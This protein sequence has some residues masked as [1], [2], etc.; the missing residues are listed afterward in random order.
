MRSFIFAY[1][2][3]IGL[4]EKVVIEG[5]VMDYPELS[6]GETKAT[7]FISEDLTTSTQRDYVLQ[8]VNI[9]TEWKTGGELWDDGTWVQNYSLWESVMQPGKWTAVSCTA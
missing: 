9:N 8:S 7:G 6:D 1:F 4:T 3:T 2:A 5:T